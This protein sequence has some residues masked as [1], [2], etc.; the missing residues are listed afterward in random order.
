MAGGRGAREENLLDRSSLADLWHSQKK[1]SF[2]LQ[3]QHEEANQSIV[4]LT[5]SPVLLYCFIASFILI[6]ESA[7]DMNVYIWQDNEI[8]LIS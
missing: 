5:F 6:F 7:S 1:K 2:V 4:G 8:I 3:C